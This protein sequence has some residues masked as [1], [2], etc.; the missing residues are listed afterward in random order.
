[1]NRMVEAPTTA[2][3]LLARIAKLPDEERRLLQDRIDKFGLNSRQR[4]FVEE[5]VVSFDSKD[6]ARAAG[7]SG[8]PAK[9]LQNHVGVQAAVDE[10][11][12]E[13]AA[14]SELKAEYVR[15][16]ILSILELCP[17]DYFMTGPRGEWMIDP[18]LFKTLPHEVKRLVDSVELKIYRG[19]ATFCVKFISKQA[20]LAMAARYTLVQKVD[21]RVTQVPW[22]ELAKEAE[23]EVA[24]PIAQR[25]K[26]YEL[27]AIEGPAE[28]AE[29]PVAEGDLL[30]QTG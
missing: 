11:L 27:L 16:Y 12:A 22:D 9:K 5:Y 18:E 15:E 23:R 26:K 17:T 24:D 20:A 21:A 14:K 19:E 6:A 2:D 13:L 1:M 29:V 8:T 10:K 25:L 28:V 3:E 7:Y 4:R 30:R